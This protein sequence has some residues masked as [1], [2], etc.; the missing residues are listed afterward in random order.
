M[1][2]LP[3]ERLTALGLAL[4]DHVERGSAGA[5]AQGTVHQHPTRP[6][7]LVK[8]YRPGLVPRRDVL[9]ALGSLATDP[10]VIGGSVLRERFRLPVAL[11]THDQAGHELCCGFVMEDVGD[12]FR[13]DVE[14]FG[15]RRSL[16]LEAQHLIR[17]ENAATLRL[18]GPDADARLELVALLLESLAALHR[19]GWLAQD[20]ISELNIVWCDD[21]DVAFIDTDSMRPMHGLGIVP[22]CHSPNY[23]PQTWAPA[24]QCADSDVW[25]AALLCGRILAGT[26]AWPQVADADAVGGTILGGLLLTAVRDAPSA[27]RPTMHELANATRR[28]STGGSQSSF[29]PFVMPAVKRTPARSYFLPLP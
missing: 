27:T 17:W 28:L 4:P 10:N 24:A 20:V 6:G 13:R 19:A 26:A 21:P 18:P 3:I 9:D 2:P 12:R 1:S 15:S 16:L 8:L 7:H 14:S 22:P 23:A 11:V 25:K 29:V 5:G